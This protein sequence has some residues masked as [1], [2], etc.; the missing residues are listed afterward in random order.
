MMYPLILRKCLTNP[1]GHGHGYECHSPFRKRA[2][3][4]AAWAVSQC[5]GRYPMNGWEYKYGKPS[6]GVVYIKWAGEL[7]GLVNLS[8]CRLCK[9]SC[10]LNCYIT[11]CHRKIV[12]L[13]PLA[14]RK[15]KLGFLEAK[16]RPTLPW[17]QLVCLNI[18]SNILLDYQ[19]IWMFRNSAGAISLEILSTGRHPPR[20]AET[21]WTT[22]VCEKKKPR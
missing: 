17:A 22:G 4:F 19:T 5:A 21:P 12:I 14:A 20:F 11:V 3:L 15:P 18:I 8:V 13:L 7:K 9:G 6:F 2:C 10:C 16:P 1:V